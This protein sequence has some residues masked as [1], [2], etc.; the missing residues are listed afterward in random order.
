MS[1]SS[2]FSCGTDAESSFSFSRCRFSLATPLVTAFVR[3]D[4]GQCVRS[5]ISRVNIFCCTRML[6]DVFLTLHNGNDLQDCKNPAHICGVNV[7]SLRRGAV[8]SMFNPGQSWVDTTRYNIPLLSDDKTEHP[9]QCLICF[10]N[11]HRRIGIAKSPRT[12]SQ[13]EILRC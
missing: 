12:G 8:V 3:P 7:R 6:F 5:I 1:S 2:S 9:W 11:A 13:R 10:R 4:V